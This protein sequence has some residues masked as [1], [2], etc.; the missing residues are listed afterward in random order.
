M[1]KHIVYGYRIS[2]YVVVQYTHAHS[3]ITATNRGT[4]IEFDLETYSDAHTPL[5]LAAAN[6]YL[7]IV[8]YCSSIRL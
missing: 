4:D 2:N 3:L 5:H 8:G 1:A 7:E 6:G